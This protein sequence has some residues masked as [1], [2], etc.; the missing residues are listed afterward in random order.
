MDAEHEEH[1]NNHLN[2]RG[3]LTPFAKELLEQVDKG[4]NMLSLLNGSGRKGHHEPRQRTKREMQEHAAFLK[5]YRA[6]VDLGLSRGYLTDDPYE[7][8][9]ERLYEDKYDEWVWDETEE[10]FR[11]RVKDLPPVTFRKVVREPRDEA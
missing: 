5:A 1:V 8:V 7:G 6:V 9:S 4:F 2:F 3:F 10:E 11:E